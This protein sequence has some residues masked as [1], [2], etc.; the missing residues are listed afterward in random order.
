M[1]DPLG[2]AL[3][4]AY[5]HM[6]PLPRKLPPI[7]TIKVIKRDIIDLS[8]HRATPQLEEALFTLSSQHQKPAHRILHAVIAVSG[9]TKVELCTPGRFKKVAH[10]RHILSYLLRTK[11]GLSSPDIAKRTGRHDHTSV[12]NSL[13]VVEK[14]PERFAQDIADVEM[15]LNG[16]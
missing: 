9:L 11:A 13:K 5:P 8:T 4:K 15:L 7:Q 2:M 16:E 14:N 12:L 1:T 10:W 3:M 6:K